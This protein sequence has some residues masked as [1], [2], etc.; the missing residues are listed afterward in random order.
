MYVERLSLLA[1]LT[2][3][4]PEALMAW[5][6]VA[7]EVWRCPGPKEKKINCAGRLASKSCHVV[8]WIEEHHISRVF[9]LAAVILPNLFAITK[10][11]LTSFKTKSHFY[12]ML[13]CILLWTMEQYCISI[14]HNHI[15]QLFRWN[16][17]FTIEHLPHF[18]IIDSYTKSHKSQPNGCV[19]VCL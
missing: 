2:H 18:I 4:C 6:Y 9:L 17:K 16:N 11:S 1:T 19:V 8:L 5:I 15:L 3:L 12:A 7:K 13:H 14:H 10:I